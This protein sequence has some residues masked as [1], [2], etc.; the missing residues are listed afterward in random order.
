MALTWITGNTTTD[1]T[2]QTIST[3]TDS[4]EYQLWLDL[5]NL[6]AGDELEVRIYTQDNLSD[7]TYRLSMPVMVFQGINLTIP[8]VYS[9]PLPADCGWRASIKRT[10]GTDRNYKWKV[11]KKS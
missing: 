5:H 4:A 10:A 11:A 3:Q 6:A 8:H 9:P 1:G 2:E 7:T